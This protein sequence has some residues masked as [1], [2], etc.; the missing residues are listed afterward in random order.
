MSEFLETTV[1]KFIFKVA[2]DRFY[3]DSHLWVK[4]EDGLARVGL[5]DYLQ[6]TSGDVAFVEAQAEGAEL[7]PGDELANIETM[8]TSL[9]VPS[10]VGGVVK[11]V[12]PQLED[13]PELVNQDPYGQGWLILVEAG[14]WQ[15]D[16]ADLLDANAYYALMKTEAE[17]EARQL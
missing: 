9:I 11:A 8:K 3:T 10:P 4:L 13:E 6:Q 7:A 17:E 14:D 16:S 12:N 15:A 5:S 1:D 2:T